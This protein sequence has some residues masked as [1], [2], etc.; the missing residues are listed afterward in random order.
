MKKQMIIIDESTRNLD[1]IKEWSY[2]I[3]LIKYV[4][5]LYRIE[6]QVQT[7]TETQLYVFKNGWKKVASYHD[8]KRLISKKRSQLAKAKKLMKA[9]QKLDID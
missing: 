6:Q 7:N 5:R 8:K 4:D 9:I 2:T 3:F 1:T